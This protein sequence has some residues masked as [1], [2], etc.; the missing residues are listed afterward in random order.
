MVTP[1]NLA[2]GAIA[3]VR[4]KRRMSVIV[5]LTTL[6]RARSVALYGT[7]RMPEPCTS[8]APRYLAPP[9]TR[10]GPSMS[11]REKAMSVSRPVLS[12]VPVTKPTPGESYGAKTTAGC[13]K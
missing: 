2:C 6:K 8:T 4:S 1:L 9:V 3:F 11:M 12:V 7:S 13:G 5:L 10:P